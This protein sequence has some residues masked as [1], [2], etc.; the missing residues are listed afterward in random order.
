MATVRI[1]RTAQATLSKAFY[2]DEQVSASTGPVSVVVSRLDGTVVQSGTAASNPDG[3]Y[4]FVFA[5]R[6][7]LDELVATW[8]ATIGGDPIVLDQDH[9]EIVGGFFFTLAQGRA[10]DRVLSDTTKFPTA[11]LV[12]RRIEVEDECERITGQAW[13]PRFARETVRVD[14]SRVIRL[15]WPFVRAVRSVTVS[16]TAYTPTSISDLGLIYR[17]AGW[18]IGTGYAVVEYE[19]GHDRPNSEI[20]R[21]SRIRFK[22]LL[23]EGRSALPDRAERVV[24]VNQ[25]G[26]SIVYG[27]ATAEKTGLPAVDAV[28][29]RY[30]SPQPG[31]G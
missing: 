6:D 5:G 27:A 23:L 31:F 21:G 17:D 11:D 29:G 19:H 1:L 12:D 22:S 26:G 20:V 16:G 15:K 28:Y 4:D 25:D 14:G 7:V 2:L 24:Q 30:P 18:P 9:I 3:G 8:S 10:V 13:V